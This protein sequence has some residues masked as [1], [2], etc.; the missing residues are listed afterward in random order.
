MKKLIS[1]NEKIT[2]EVKYSKLITGN[3]SYKE[4]NKKISIDTGIDFKN[5]SE[6]VLLVNN[7]RLK[8]SMLKKSL[9]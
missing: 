5:F 9:L 7:L 3:N 2:I 1:M 8:D 4:E 6:Y